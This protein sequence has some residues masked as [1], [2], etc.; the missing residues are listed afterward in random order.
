MTQRRPPEQLNIPLVWE[1]NADESPSPREGPPLNEMQYSPVFR[2]WQLW[3]A[4]LA[5]LGF[6]LACLF[7]AL[8]AVIM[9]GGWSGTAVFVFAWGLALDLAFV[10]ALAGVWA[11]RG[12]PGMLLMGLAF[13][14]PLPLSRAA[15]VLFFWGGSLLLVG[16][17]LV[18]K[19]RGQ[20]LAERLAEV[21]ISLH[22]FR[23][24]A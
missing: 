16:I 24:G 8:L 9:A 14:Q 20:T 7:V 15:K 19:R 5:D 13:T 2:I 1:Q 12:T 11:W 17:P 23:E 22:S 21:P 6:L 3:L 10:I 18:I 4:A